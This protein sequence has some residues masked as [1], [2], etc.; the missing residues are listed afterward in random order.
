MPVEVILNKDK[1]NKI[2]VELREKVK[3]PKVKVYS[4]GR[5]R[6]YEQLEFD[7]KQFN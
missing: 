7:F 4:D 3:L 1:N 2:V 6:V 5:G